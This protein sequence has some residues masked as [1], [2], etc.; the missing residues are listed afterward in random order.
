[1][2]CEN[3]GYKREGKCTKNAQRCINKYPRDLE[4]WIKCQLLFFL[5]FVCLSPRTKPRWKNQACLLTSSTQKAKLGFV[6]GAVAWVLSSKW[7]YLP[8]NQIPIYLSI[9]CLLVVVFSAAAR[10]G[11][12]LHLHGQNTGGSILRT[13]TPSHAIQ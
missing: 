1:M 9:D 6:P 2:G 8:H 3:G 10:S 12:F 4:G 13:A 7:L 5:C 11:Y